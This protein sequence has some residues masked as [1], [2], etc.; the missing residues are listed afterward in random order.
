MTVEDKQQFIRLLKLTGRYKE[1]YEAMGIASHIVKYHRSK[2]KQFDKLCKQARKA[3]QVK[4]FNQDAFLKTY[5]QEFVKSY[6]TALRIMYGGEAD[7][8]QYN[9]FYY[10]LTHCGTF[11]AQVLQIK[12]N[13]QCKE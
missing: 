2:D 13:K 10:T 5:S 3:S 9:K 8:K 11:R 4:R 1:A 6:T 12:T 7:V